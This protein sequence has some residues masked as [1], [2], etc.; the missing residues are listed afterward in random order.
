M[1]FTVSGKLRYNQIGRKFAFGVTVLINQVYG[2]GM[3]EAGVG[4]AYV[5]GYVVITQ[6]FIKR[7]SCGYLSGPCCE[8]QECFP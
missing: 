4:A 2:P 8:E 7:V 1:D 3:P 6:S 5:N